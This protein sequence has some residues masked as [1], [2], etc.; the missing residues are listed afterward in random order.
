M[1]DGPALGRVGYDR[2]AHHRSDASWLAEAWP[3][4]RVLLVSPDGRTPTVAGADGR[5]A[6]RLAQPV[7]VAAA[8]SRRLL[9]VV[10]DVP[11]F[12]VTVVESDPP[13]AGLREIGPATD[14]L[15]AALLTSAVAL[16]LWHSRH[17][18]CP[19]C[20]TPTA[21]SL[22]GWTRTCPR[23]SSEHFPRTDPAVI[24]VVHDGGDRCLLGRGVAWGPGRFSTLAGFV[25]P[26]ESLEAAVAR[27]V[28]EE[29]GV[30][31][32]DAR[33]VASQPWP[34]PASLMI[35][36]VARAE[37]DTT[38]HVDGIEVAEAGWFTRA[39]VARAA[40]RADGIGEADPDAVLQAVSPKLSISR[41]LVDSWVAGEI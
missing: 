13:W 15:D 37:V 16:Q 23:D 1:V 14:D 17:T 4:S 39:E 22:A 33:Y 31:V 18:H 10:D 25:E 9:G 8:A 34:F 24:M 28:R 5:R 3:R 6:L 41:Y 29:V 20:G 36:F 38:L 11:Y 12:S 26:G 2:A 32:T 27:E 19:R 35:G 7:D 30:A 40:A 21:E